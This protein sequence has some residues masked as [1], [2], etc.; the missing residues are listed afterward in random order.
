MESPGYNLARLRVLLYMF[1]NV[2]CPEIF[3]T[4]TDLK[5]GSES[6]SK[7]ILHLPFK[8]NTVKSVA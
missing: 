6:E 1:I 4:E 8:S 2:H 3:Y 7:N 5:P